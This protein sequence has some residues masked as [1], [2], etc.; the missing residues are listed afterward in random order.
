MD[1]WNVLNVLPD[2]IW[3]VITPEK[4]L[5]EILPNMLLS[6]DLVTKDV[7]VL[8]PVMFVTNVKSPTELGTKMKFRTNVSPVERKTETPISNTVKP[9]PGIK[10]SLNPSVTPVWKDLMMMFLTLLDLIEDTPLEESM[11]LPI[12]EN[13]ESVNPVTN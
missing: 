12:L 1:L 10:I 2:I 5:I 9:V 3:P 8:N 13:T 11:D 4:L 7:N 6:V